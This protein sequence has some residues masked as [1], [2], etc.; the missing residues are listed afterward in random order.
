MRV[1]HVDWPT[2]CSIWETAAAS[3]SRLGAVTVRK[4]ENST[5]AWPA[6]RACSRARTSSYSAASERSRIWPTLAFWAE[7]VTASVF[8]LRICLSA[9]LAP[10]GRGH[11]GQGT[12][13]ALGEEDGVQE[14]R[15][16]VLAGPFAYP[17]HC[18]E[19]RV[20]A[21]VAPVFGHPDRAGAAQRCPG[22][23]RAQG[24]GRVIGLADD[25]G[26]GRRHRASG[27]CAARRR[28]MSSPAPPSGCAAQTAAPFTPLPDSLMALAALRMSR[29][30]VMVVRWAEEACEDCASRGGVV[31]IGPS[32]VVGAVA[33]VEAGDAGAR[34]GHSGFEDLDRRAV[35]RLGQAGQQPSPGAHPAL[36]VAGREQDVGRMGDGDGDREDLAVRVVH[37]ARCALRVLVEAQRGGVAGKGHRAGRTRRGHSGPVLMLSGH[38]CGPSRSSRRGPTR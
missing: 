30:S 33:R 16:H 3:S 25:D 36:L 22:R 24:R 14:V 11:Q 27:R 29:E 32:S 34:V 1:S 31:G 12:P 10:S 17:Q 15:C 23:V 21:Q 28:A 13:H 19:T 20:V 38:A 9:S 4:P 8:S 35:P 7:S 18:G 2:A 5:S 37:H 26:Q 6:M